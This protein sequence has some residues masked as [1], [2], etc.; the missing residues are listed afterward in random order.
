MVSRTATSLFH[1]P[2]KNVIFFLETK[3]N[4]DKKP[5]NVPANDLRL[6]LQQKANCQKREGAIN[7]RL[8]RARKSGDSEKPTQ[9]LK[10]K[11]D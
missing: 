10:E 8:D 6:L 5:K 3:R 4:S 9:A 7:E 11:L 2:N 1:V